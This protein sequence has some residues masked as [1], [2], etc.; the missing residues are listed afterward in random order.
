MLQL[1]R[2]M[3]WVSRRAKPSARGGWEPSNVSRC[4]AQPQNAIRRRWWDVA[5]VVLLTT[6]CGVEAPLSYDEAPDSK[7]A[8]RDTEA[9]DTAGSSGPSVGQDDGAPGIVAERYPEAPY[10]TTRGA[11]I[12]NLRWFGWS[13]PVAA[14]FDLDAAHAVSLSDFYNPDGDPD[15][16]EYILLNAVASWCSVCRSEYQDLRNKG[17]YE[18]FGPRGL[19]V[20]GVL[21]EDNDG[22]PSTYR[23]LLNWTRAYSVE[24]PF[25]NDPG[26]RSGVFFDKSATPMNMLI[27]ARTMKIEL[28][29]TGYNPLIYDQIDKLLTQRGK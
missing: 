27:D 2:S 28:L 20:F 11:T 10:G 7:G 19:Q 24:F 22:E 1:P 15:R 4:W 12:E 18:E 21:F 29:M 25:V 26:F 8:G 16:P 17:I 14:G 23:D 13:N 9:V 5:G 6:A 3:S